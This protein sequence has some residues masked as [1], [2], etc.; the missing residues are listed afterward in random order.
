MNCLLSKEEQTTKSRT[1]SYQ[2]PQLP[3]ATSRNANI[4]D[5]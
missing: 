4:A 3:T 5:S 2:Q 1:K